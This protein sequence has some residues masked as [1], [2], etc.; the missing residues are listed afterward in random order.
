MIKLEFDIDLTSDEILGGIQSNL[1]AAM[2]KTVSLT[3]AKAEQLAASKLKSGLEHWTKG[4]K[5]TR[6]D[7]GFWVLEVEGEMA[8]MMEEGFAAGAI[9]EMLLNGNRARTNQAMTGKRYV[10]V[11]L[12]LNADAMTGNI[13]KTN[14]SVS[15]FKNADE[16]LQSIKTSDWKRGGIKKEQRITQRVKD[17]I[18]TRKPTESASQFI[19]IKRVSEKSTGWPTKPFD[20]AKVLDKLDDFLEKAFFESLNSLL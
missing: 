9:K 18:K 3:Q 10:D 1:D 11:P 14:V 16:L 5:I 12:K 17:V 7:S 6:I 20:G 15:Q 2:A 8:N 19:T 13:G 4:F